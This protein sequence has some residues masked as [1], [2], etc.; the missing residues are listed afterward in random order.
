MTITDTPRVQNQNILSYAT[1][2]ADMIKSGHVAKRAMDAEALINRLIDEFEAHVEDENAYLL[3][4]LFQ[5]PNQ[6]VR[7]SA[8]RSHAMLNEVVPHVFDWGHKWRAS[9]IQTHPDHFHKE[10]RQVFMQ[11]K[12]QI[13]NENVEL[14]PLAE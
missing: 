11:L 7:E 14:F 3:P 13:D 8:H 12:A 6:R 9:N 1:E 5:H 10:T 2:I 4:H